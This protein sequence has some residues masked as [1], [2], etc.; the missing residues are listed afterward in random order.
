LKLHHHIVALSGLAVF[1][2]LASEPSH[3]RQSRFRNK[4]VESRGQNQKAEPRV[5]YKQ[6]NVVDFD[7]SLIEGDV[8]NP[9]DFYF[10]HRPQEKFGTLVKRRPNFHKEMLRDTVMIR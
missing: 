3:A 1:L 4:S 8:K 2:L 7:S 5:V 6:R 9:T 10:V